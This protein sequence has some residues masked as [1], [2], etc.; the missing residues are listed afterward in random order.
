MSKEGTD[1]MPHMSRSPQEG[2]LNMKMCVQNYK[3]RNEGIPCLQSAPNTTAFSLFLFYLVHHL[4][5]SVVSFSQLTFVDEA[6]DDSL[7]SSSATLIVS[8]ANGV[9]A[10]DRQ[11]QQSAREPESIGKKAA[12]KDNEAADSTKYDQ[13]NGGTTEESEVNKCITQ[14]I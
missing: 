13:V 12:T 5:L 6:S 10:S 8:I 2:Y 4:I 3:Y 11:Q 9:V 7:A 1:Q 14:P